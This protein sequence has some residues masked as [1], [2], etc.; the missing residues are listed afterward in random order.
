MKKMLIWI[1]LSVSLNAFAEERK[2]FLAKVSLDRKDTASIKRGATFFAA[3]CMSC[4]TLV[5]LRYNKLAK[6]AGITYER[7]P[8][9]VKTWPFGIKPPDLSLEAKVRGVD[10]IYTYLHSFYVDTTRP[11]G[12]NN[13]LV[14]N[15][16][17]SGIL[18]PYQGQQF[19]T[20]TKEGQWY[21]ILVLQN[22]LFIET[23]F[24]NT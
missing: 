9:N 13:L 11:T 5:Y 22:I 6:E 24:L 2:I 14:M 20:D 3:N 8:L 21:D 15:T 23:E 1:F 18:M 19:L 7:M 12:F 17:M 16:V 10:W 4:H